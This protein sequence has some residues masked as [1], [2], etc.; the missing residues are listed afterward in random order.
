MQW[1]SST[2]KAD[3]I[4]YAFVLSPCMEMAKCMEGMYLN[5]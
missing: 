1:K 2:D 3:P 4:A 5:D